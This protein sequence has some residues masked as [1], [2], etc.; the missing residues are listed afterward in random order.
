MS[1]LQYLP[2]I[3][4]L[5]FNLFTLDHCC[6]KK[7]SAL[8]TALVLFVFSAVLL[9]VSLMF[10]KE[11]SFEGDGKLSLLGFIY[12][13]PFRFLY[14]EKTS[15]LITI[16]CT[17]WVYTLGILSLSMQLADV[18]GISQ[19]VYIFSIETVL[20][21]VTAFPFYKWVVPKYIFVIE[22]IGTFEKRWYQ[23]IAVS[24]CLNFLLLVVLN[25][26]LIEQK[27]SIL[28]ILCVVLLLSSIYVSYFILYKIVLDS[29]KM[30][31]LE[32][33]ALHDALTGL[34]NRAQLWNHLHALLQTQQTFSV[35]FMDL[36]RF[37]E[38]N[39]HYGHLVGDQYLK[40]F[41]KISSAILQ[42]R[43]EVFRFGGDEFVA[44]CPGTVPQKTIE[45]LKKC[46]EWENGAPCPFNQVS[47]GMLLCKPPHPI[48]DAE[49]ILH[50]VDQMMYQNKTAKDK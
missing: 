27:A 36:D 40:H 6:H 7:Y 45:Q 17:C 50:R 43:G 12:L 48:K 41:A 46:R 2:A 13:L 34:G 20:F 38:I 3:E 10:A 26:I 33:V 35:L 32:H 47:I 1:I 25:A 30:N 18:L 16:V 29:I 8:K 5:I 11:I 44:V 9:M 39:D 23:Y 49:E 31:Q 42:G 28:K 22:N 19:P 21:L 4:L 15:L 24:N 37:K 14:K